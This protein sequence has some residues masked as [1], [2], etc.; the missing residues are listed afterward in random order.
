MHEWMD[1]WMDGWLDGWLDGWMNEL[2][3][4]QTYLLNI[5][6]I[7]KCWFTGASH[8]VSIE[9]N[10]TTNSECIIDTKMLEVIMTN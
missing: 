4:E 3:S 5:A 8:I 10:M 2:M 6:P 7:P 1:G 9:E